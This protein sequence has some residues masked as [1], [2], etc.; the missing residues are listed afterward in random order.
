MC[1]QGP[2][3]REI[4]TEITGADCSNEA[5]PYY[6]FREDCTIG[7]M[8]VF[9]GRMGFTAELGYEIWGPADRALDIW[10]RVFEAGA[11]HDIR[12]A[13]AAAIMMMRLEAGMVM[14]EFEYDSS[15]TPFEC[16][17]GW[18]VPRDKASP[19]VGSDALAKARDNPRSRV[20]SAV[21]PGE[22][23]GADGLPITND[24]REV[25]NVTMAMASP[26]LDFKTLAFVR[27]EPGLT[28]PGT[29]ISLDI[30]GQ[31]HPGEVVATPVYDPERK[32]VHS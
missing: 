8:P 5:F 1:L 12:A 9:L 19:Y 29:K 16:R 30:D 14:A 28:E 25:G 23:E 10:D 21:F 15:T 7:D 31:S 3:S 24:G 20:V 2:K 4:L 32:R 6:T 26:Y 11:K 22:I 18:A 27:I 13:G 17:L